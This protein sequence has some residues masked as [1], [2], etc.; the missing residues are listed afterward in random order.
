MFWTGAVI[1][2][3]AIL[4][5]LIDS[6][7]TPKNVLTKV[8][9]TLFI[10]GFLPLGLSYFYQY[11]DFENIEITDK[12]Y[13]EFNSDELIIDNNQKINYKDINELKI[14]IVAH[15][16]ERINVIYNTPTE[17][18]SLGLSNEIQIST[19]SK[20]IKFNFKLENESHVKRLEKFM[21]E[22]VI[23]EKLSN[24]SA[25]TTIKL[26]PERYRKSTGYKNYVINQLIA[27]RINCTEGLLLH[28]YKS[29]KEAKVL[30]EKYCG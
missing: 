18:R 12:G 26:I 15:Y 16:N 27:K 1:I 4:V 5:Y 8:Q 13:F 30:R 11:F 3:L 10:I 25:K 21:F 28:G 29:D 7:I 20:N 2:G 9:Y 24:L 6:Q 19:S 17:T 14:N 23:S 22:L